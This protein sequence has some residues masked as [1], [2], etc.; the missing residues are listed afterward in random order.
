MNQLET[1]NLREDIHRMIQIVLK[2]QESYRIV[3]YLMQR[4]DDFYIQNIK[5]KN[6]FLKSVKHTYWQVTVIELTKLFYFNHKDDTQTKNREHFNLRDFLKKLGTENVY[7][8]VNISPFILNRW[9]QEIKKCNKTVLNLITLRD[10]LYAH[11]DRN[12]K[13]VINQTTLKH[14]MPLFSIA[15]EILSVASINGLNEGN[16][17]EVIGSPVKELEKMVVQIAKVKKDHMELYRPILKKY[18]LEN[19]LP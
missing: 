8:W 11:D 6:H 15:I 16:S 12:N 7:S 13:D 4:D 9:Q 19:E 5:R 3:Y 18:D 1:A 14:L 17:F 10:K 2:A